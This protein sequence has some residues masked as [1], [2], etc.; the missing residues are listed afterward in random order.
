MGQ[1]ERG[2]EGTPHIQFYLNF[3]KPIKIGGLKKHCRHSHFEPVKV[4]NGAA[5]YCMKEDTRV[6]GPWEFGV[7]P[8]QRNSKTDWEEVKV[9]A[10]KGELNKIPADIYVKHYSMLRLIAKD[11]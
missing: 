6:A 2:A 1:L 7:K 4:D 10:Q 9:N 11:H 5:K 8:V 3:Q